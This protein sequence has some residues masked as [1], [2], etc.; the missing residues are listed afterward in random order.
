MTLLIPYI[1]HLKGDNI[2]VKLSWHRFQLNDVWCQL[3][4]SSYRDIVSK[5]TMFDPTVI[6]IELS[7]HLL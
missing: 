7:R 1:Y 3:S 6:D 2:F 4:L 5:Y